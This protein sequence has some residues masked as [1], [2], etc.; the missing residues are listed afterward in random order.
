[1][2]CADETQQPTNQLSD[3]LSSTASDISRITTPLNPNAQQE[4][5]GSD[6]QQ[7][8]QQ[9]QQQQQQPMNNPQL[10]QQMNNPQ[11]PQQMGNQPPQSQYNGGMPQ[12]TGNGSPPPMQENGGP[13]QMQGNSGPPQMQMQGGNGPPQ[14][15]GNGPPQMQGNGP[16]QM[17]GNGSPQMQGNGPP[18]MQGNVPP[19]MQGNGPPKMGG[20]GNPLPFSNEILQSIQNYSKQPLF[21]GQPSTQQWPLKGN[22]NAGYGNMP[23]SPNTPQQQSQQMPTQYPQKLMSSMPLRQQQPQY[24]PSS[25]SFNGESM[26]PQMGN[27]PSLMPQQSI[28]YSNPYQ[29][30]YSMPQNYP[31]NDNNVPIQQ[32]LDSGYQPNSGNK[33]FYCVSII[34]IRLLAD[35]GRA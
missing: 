18:Q 21:T 28:E 35:I 25:P 7:Q 32:T 26:R 5:T 24:F 31:T 15:Q 10:Q 12:M 19:Q 34:I 23:F 11:I 14:M 29:N 1:M 13:P 4:S 33:L 16:P 17:Q 8:L 27:Q 30:Q 22:S 2:Y 6:Q 3:I 9:Q 20:V